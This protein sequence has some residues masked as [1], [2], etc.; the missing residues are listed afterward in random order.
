M[1]SRLKR[2]LRQIPVAALL[3]PAFA[4]RALI[5]GG[6]MPAMTGDGTLTLQ[7]CPAIVAPLEA[8]AHAH[9]G[10]A[11]GGADSGHTHQDGGTDGAGSHQAVCPFAAS[12]S[13]AR[14]PAVLAFASVAMQ[15]VLVAHRD[16]EQVSFSK[17]PRT[18][19]PRAPP[20]AA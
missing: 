12:A 18:Q 20:R 16:V 10:H 9:H 6:F 1:P 8:G 3:L 13:P 14:A 5:P 7:F 4:F 2:T 15:H 19:S 11:G 17:L